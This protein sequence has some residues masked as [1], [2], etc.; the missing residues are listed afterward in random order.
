MEKKLNTLTKKAERYGRLATKDGRNNQKYLKDYLETVSQISDL[1]KQIK[2]KSKK[3]NFQD[4]PIVPDSVESSEVLEVPETVEM[5]QQTQKQRQQYKKK[6]NI[7][8][9][10]NK[11]PRG[12]RNGTYQECKDLRQIRLFGVNPLPTTTK[13][14]GYFQ[15]EINDMLNVP[16]SKDINKMKMSELKSFIKSNRKMK[17]INSKDYPVHKLNKNQLRQLAMQLSELK[18]GC[19]C[20]DMSGGAAVYQTVYG[21]TPEIFR[22]THVELQDMTMNQIKEMIRKHNLHYRIKNFH[23]L[24]KTNLIQAIAELQSQYKKDFKVR[25]VAK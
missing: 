10:A 7:Y 25:V 19:S 1:Q 22:L 3:V 5:I 24:N 11:V 16:E 21:A 15:H 6:D 13:K 8:C 23:R 20:D 4:V 2:K 17:E 14:G 9:G 12:Q 18:G